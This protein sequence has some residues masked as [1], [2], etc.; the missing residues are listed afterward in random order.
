MIGWMDMWNVDMH[1][2]KDGWAGQ[3]TVPRELHIKNGK[4]ISTPAKELEKLHL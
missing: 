4:I 1:E 3:M 2:A